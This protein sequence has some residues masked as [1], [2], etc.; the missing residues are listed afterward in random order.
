M[1][2]VAGIDDFPA[3]IRQQV[4]NDIGT[5]ENPV[6]TAEVEDT[7]IWRDAREDLLDRKNHVGG[8]II[9]K[10]YRGKNGWSP[11]TTN[12]DDVLRR[13]PRMPSWVTLNDQAP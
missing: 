13:W 5:R 1:F 9:S 3:F 8:S 12:L 4:N 7:I 11:A 10:R 2:P 6:R